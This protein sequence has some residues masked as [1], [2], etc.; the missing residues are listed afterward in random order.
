LAIAKLLRDKEVAARYAIV[1]SHFF[2][3]AD[4]VLQETQLQP[5]E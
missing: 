3:E 1:A 4:R 2:E 5:A